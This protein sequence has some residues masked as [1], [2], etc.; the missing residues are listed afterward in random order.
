M[1]AAL[2]ERL[3]PALCP[4]PIHRDE[5]V[6]EAFARQAALPDAAPHAQATHDLQGAWRWLQ[7][8]FAPTAHQAAIDAAPDAAT[9]AEL[10]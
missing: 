5:A 8:R 7:A 3:G 2:L 4:Y 6:P 9:A 1:H 10:V